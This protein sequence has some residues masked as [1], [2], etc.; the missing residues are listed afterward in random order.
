M[1]E[2]HGREDVVGLDVSGTIGWFTTRF[3]VRFELPAGADPEPAIIAVKEQLRAVPHNGLSYGALK[4][5]SSDRATPTA[6]ALTEPESTFNYLGRL[7]GLGGQ[8]W[9]SAPEPPGAMVSPRNRPTSR[10]DITAFVLDGQL[11][12]RITTN[13]PAALG[14]WS[15]AADFLERLR[16]VIAHCR[17]QRATRFTPS[18]FPEKFPGLPKND[19]LDRALLG[20]TAPADVYCLTPLQEGL[21]FHALHSPASDQYVVQ[22]EW[23]CAAAI[24]PELL[25]RA[26]VQLVA[27]HDVLRTRF[28]WRGLR[29][30]VQI[31]EAEAQPAW[32]MAD[33]SG[34]DGDATEA[35]IA[36]ERAAERAPGFDLER[37]GAL[38]IA[39]LRQ[40]ADRWVLLWTYHHILL[41]GWCVPLLLDELG[42]RYAALRQG[43][44]PQWARRRP[45]RT[46]AISAGCIARIATGRCGSGATK[47]EGIHGIDR[48]S[49]APPRHCLRRARACG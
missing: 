42:R 5:L 41:D 18:D 36:A 35:A 8:G 17:N 43:S 38:R 16:A 25:H 32:R 14:R 37:P 9:A 1:L 23:L 7:D 45:P 19:E 24:E 21:L 12:T 46:G 29:H 26:C 22:F 44:G 4:E 39:L 3:P 27:A 34:L 10:L 33:L 47:L 48:H 15:I 28:A 13:L 2:G 11:Q 30:P 40:R 6:L 31:V 20:S 49:G